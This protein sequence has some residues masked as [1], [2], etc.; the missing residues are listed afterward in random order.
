MEFRQATFDDTDMIADLMIISFSDSFRVLFG[1][2]MNKGKNVLIE[3]LKLGNSLD[4]VFVAVDNNE[5]VGV[6]VLKIKETQQK[7]G[8]IIKIF[9]KN[10]G[11]LKGLKTIF[12]GGYL[13]PSIEKNKCLLDYICIMPEARCRGIGKK[14]IKYGENYVTKMNKKYM[15]SFISPLEGRIHILYK[16]G[17]EK[18]KVKKSIA[19][20]FFFKKPVWVYIEKKIS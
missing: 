12:L 18:K 14:L 1:K 17:F 11:L 6:L 8:S 3:Y 13:Q 19:S 16:S 2:K 7:W 9:I 15:Y 20:K 5:V 4:S 10:L